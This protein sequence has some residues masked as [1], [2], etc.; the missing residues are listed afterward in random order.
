MSA[1]EKADMALVPGFFPIDWDSD[2]TGDLGDLGTE[3]SPI[4]LD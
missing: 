4:V 1:E 3:K 2:D